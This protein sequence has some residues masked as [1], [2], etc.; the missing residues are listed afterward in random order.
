METG[1]SVKKFYA[2]EPKD[3]ANGMK[4]YLCDRK[5][6]RI[7]IYFRVDDMDSLDKKGNV[8]VKY[9]LYK[10]VPNKEKKDPSVLVRTASAPFERFV[11]TVID[12]IEASNYMCHRGQD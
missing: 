4:F 2:L 12:C 8:I 9:S 7:E 10:I 6:S 3:I 1:F 5:S 11:K